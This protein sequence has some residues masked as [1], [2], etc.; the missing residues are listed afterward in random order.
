LP[1]HLNETL[2]AHVACASAGSTTAGAPDSA[3]VE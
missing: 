3:P 2:P 1:A